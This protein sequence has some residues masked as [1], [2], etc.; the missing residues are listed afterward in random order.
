MRRPLLLLASAFALGTLIGEGVASLAAMS[1]LGSAAVLLL[2]ALS[3]KERQAPLCL[4]A[5]ALAI[6]AAIAG[7][8]AAAF[9]S[10]PLLHWNASRAVDAEGPVRLRGVAMADAQE[11]EERYLIGLRVHA[12]E[13]GGAWQPLPGS[14]RVEVAGKAPRLT[15]A[16]GDQIVLWAQLREPRGFGNPGAIDA[17]AQLRRAGFH[18]LGYCKS[19]RLVD[20]Q[21]E[22]RST[23]L[24]KWA[25]RARR[26]ARETLK[27]GVL[28]GE[29]QGLIRA[30]VLGDRTGIGP[31]T[32]EAFKIAGI[33][34][35]LA[36]SGAQIALVAGILLWALG[37]L[38]APPL[39]S[40][41]ATSGALVFYSIL[42]GGDA[43][44]TRAA[45]MVI[46]LLVGKV[47]DLES[48]MANLL[49]LAALLHLV[50]WPAAIRDVAFQL[51]FVA[52]LGILLLTPVW[53]KRCPALPL[54]LHLVVL[55]SLAA[56][57][58]LVP[59]LVT[60]FHRLSPAALL[61]NLAA[62]PL[63][64]G[65]LIT[66]IGFLLVAAVA[67]GLAPAVGDLAW[68]CAHVLLRSG[69]ISRLAP[70]LDGRLPTP[71]FWA[72]ALYS[73]ALLGLARPGPS[74]RVVPLLI[75]GF[76]GL[77]V[78][79]QA[80]R[81][82]GR[83]HL[84][85]LDVGQGDC[86]VL[87]SPRGRL[88]IVDTG[89]FFDS[90]F[91]VGEAVLGPYLWSQRARSVDRLVITHAHP[92]HAGGVPFLLKTFAVKEVW[93]GLAP[94][95]DSIY[96][97]L[98]R[99]LSS[100]G[101]ARVAVSAGVKRDWDGV[102]LEVLGPTPS[103]RPPWKTRNDDS[104]VLSLQMGETRFLLT[105]DVEREGEAR[106]TLGPATVLKVPHHGSRSSSTPRLLASVAPRLGIISVGFRNRFG[107]PH[108][109]IVERYMAR[110]I[111]LFRTD[112]DGAVT[113]STD[114]QRVWVRTFRGPAVETLL[115]R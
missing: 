75:A 92:D 47:L 46:V 90:R 102:A 103:A 106:L 70:E 71:P 72:I 64:G 99:A 45:I 98:A 62:V 40:C 44:V 22:S 33:Y 23:P 91:D 38:R 94:R 36:I 52:T 30:I 74:R 66:G 63:A 65:I 14:V 29:E 55:A 3:A 21:G 15:I 26:W 28:P 77:C 76:A 13:L 101:A 112:Q 50:A 34:H 85:I 67:P 27:E 87:R 11:R 88:S 60:H 32:S 31:E 93:E 73:A 61:L 43:P 41:L 56:Q 57:A 108:R 86:I 110:G 42:V 2:L 25:S 104:I 1:L 39:V 17:R 80:P 114:G 58:A 59:L 68:M 96:G 48:D 19:P 16:E 51:S 109:E 105:G 89:G 53:L 81:G 49:G 5:A 79:T 9:Y 6:G 54:G 4:F 8:D 107:H 35:V 97:A 24:R 37:R 7:T 115:L 111:R 10:A 83:F 18:L 78:P 100:S 20:V 95:Q 69:E 82:D 113:V 12:V 84:T